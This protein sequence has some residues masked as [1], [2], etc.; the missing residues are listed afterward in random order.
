MMSLNTAQPRDIQSLQNWLGG[1][2]CLA[3]EESAYL[4]HCGELVSLAPAGDNAMLQLEA[5]VEDRLVRFWQN[6]RK[7]IH[8]HY[9]QDY[10]VRIRLKSSI[11]GRYHTLSDDPNVYIYSGP[12]IQ[13]TAR[14]ILLL[15]ITFLLLMPVVICNIAGTF[16]IRVFVVVVST[17][18]YLLVL[19][20]LTRSKTIELILAGATYVGIRFRIV[21]QQLTI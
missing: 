16:S 12:L 10:T 2:G 8:K 15:L 21:M 19:S 4:A 7:V 5:W 14:A 9:F 6:F 1:N 17:I 13:Q 20:V 3:E 11:Q 18:L